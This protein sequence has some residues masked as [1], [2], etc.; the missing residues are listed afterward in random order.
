MLLGAAV[1]AF[2][3]RLPAPIATG[4]V[5]VELVAFAVGTRAADVHGSEV[6]WTRRAR[7]LGFVVVFGAAVVVG[8]GALTVVRAYHAA[9]DG[10]ASLDQAT[11]RLRAGD[12]EA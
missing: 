4:V 11:R 12:T 5:A 2:D 8:A 1:A 10:A 6:R 3:G 7:V 9:T